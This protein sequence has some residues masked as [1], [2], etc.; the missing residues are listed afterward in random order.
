MSAGGIRLAGFSLGGP[1][2]TVNWGRGDMD[3]LPWG[4][5]LG[6]E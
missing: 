3:S 2:V 6:P 1:E 4:R 5:S